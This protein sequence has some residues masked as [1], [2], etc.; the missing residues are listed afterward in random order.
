M[1]EGGFRLLGGLF[2]G[3]GI[4]PAGEALVGDLGAVFGLLVDEDGVLSRD[5]DGAV[6]ELDGD[7]AA[8]GVLAGGGGGGAADLGTDGG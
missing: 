5:G 7:G 8:Q 2:E 4:D 6:G 1:G 3:A